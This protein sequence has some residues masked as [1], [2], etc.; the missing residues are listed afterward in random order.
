MREMARPLTGGCACGAIRYVLT[1]VPF[2]AGYCHCR[3]CQ[4]A[5]G[6][7]VLAYGSVP[8][9]AFA[10]AQGEP[11]TWRSSS[12]GQRT[13]CGDCGTQ[14]TMQVDDQPD[15]VDIT[16]ASLDAPEACP[17]EFHIWT[18]ST[19]EWFR[20]GDGLPRYPQSRP[21]TAGT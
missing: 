21:H 20:T 11:R 18:R 9:S 4:A 1:A 10:V 7:P 5:S 15:I 16:L 8:R 14:L 6:A 19:I 13:F 2:D 17:P 3:T 12:F